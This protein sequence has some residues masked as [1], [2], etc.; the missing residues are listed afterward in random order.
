MA[1]I[2]RSAGNVSFGLRG[3]RHQI[4]AAS[5]ARLPAQQPQN[6]AAMLTFAIA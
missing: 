4:K 1:L 2:R 3:A 6:G 5:N